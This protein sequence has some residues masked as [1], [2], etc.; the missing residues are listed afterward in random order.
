MACLISHAR[1]TSAVAHISEICTLKLLEE[2]A[3][4]LRESGGLSQGQGL[5]GATGCWRHRSEARGSQ[6]DRHHLLQQLLPP[7]A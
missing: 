6:S 7:C 5:I 3:E 2:G 1:V 4:P